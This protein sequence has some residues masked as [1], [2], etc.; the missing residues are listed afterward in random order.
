MSQ[1]E[2]NKEDEILASLPTIREI[3]TKR[4]YWFVRTF[5]GKLFDYYYDTKKVGIG[6]NSVPIN[7][8]KN[9]PHDDVT[10]NS[11]NSYILSNIFPDKPGEATKLSNQLIDFYHKINIDDIVLMPSE[12]SN[13]IAFGKITSPIKKIDTPREKFFHNDKLEEYPNKFREVEWLKIMNKSD[14][15]GDLRAMFSSHMGL[16]NIDQYSEFI[17]GN[18]STFF[19]KEDFYYSSLFV[20]LN[21]DDELNA[22]DLQRYLESITKLYTHFCIANGIDENEELFLKIK[23]QSQG[24]NIWKWMKNAGSFGIAGIIGMAIVGS[25]PTLKINGE[26]GF[27]ASL[28]GNLFQNISGIYKDFVE[29]N[30]DE[31]EKK[32]KIENDKIDLL[33]KK[34][35][36]GF[37]TPEEIEK[38]SIQLVDSAKA[39]QIRSVESKGV[40]IEELKK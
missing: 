13:Y 6:G 26:D 17:E 19:V 16:T 35:K 32:I 33:D 29:T 22:F 7:L 5:G 23:I 14:V 27:E 8:I 12:N 39:L 15:I 38:Y 28:K 34:K 25:D 2:N 24:S 20:D 1:Q 40:D 9:A 3:P 11:L 10:F 37:L 36:L 31:E 21:E 4:R 18:L 30:L